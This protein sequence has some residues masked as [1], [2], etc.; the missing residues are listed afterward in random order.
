MATSEVSLGMYSLLGDF[1]VFL[2]H[3]LA[4]QVWDP[5]NSFT[6]KGF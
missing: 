5:E 6:I 3:F 1:T 4:V 2:A